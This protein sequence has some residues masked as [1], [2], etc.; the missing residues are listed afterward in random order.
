MSNPIVTP[1]LMKL[2]RAGLGLSHYVTKPTRNW[3]PESEAQGNE[4]EVEKLIDMELLSRSVTY[5]MGGAEPV[6]LVT[7]EGRRLAVEA[8]NA[9]N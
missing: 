2:L 1:D 8:Q 4:A 5:G 6:I 3:L 7:D 9:I